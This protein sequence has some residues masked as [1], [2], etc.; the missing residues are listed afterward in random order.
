MQSLMSDA[1]T[2]TVRD[3][4]KD[5]D[6]GLVYH[7]WSNSYREA[8]QHRWGDIPLYSYY[9]RMRASIDALL[10]RGAEVKIACDPDDQN[11]IMGW[12]CAEPPALHYVYVKEVYRR[13]GI[14]ASL[15]RACGLSSSQVIPCSH[16]TAFA[17][18]ISSNKPRLFRRVD[19]F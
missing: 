6:E 2:S 17:E 14:G 5:R 12:A 4:E 13:Q 16:W 7:S 11:L 10:A 15:V 19:L 8:V 3:Y 1:L 9:K 18:E